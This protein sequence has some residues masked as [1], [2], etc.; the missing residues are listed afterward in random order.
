M[1]WGE[2]GWPD[3]PSSRQFPRFIEGTAPPPQLGQLLGVTTDRSELKIQATVCMYDT[4]GFI[5]QCR[6][7][8]AAAF[9]G[10]ITSKDARGR[11]HRHP[12]PPP[13]AQ[14]RTL[15]FVAEGDE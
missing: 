1:V 4:S 2:R 11:R 6:S 9:R 15:F 3:L 8:A 14:H 12:P 7:G 5:Y 13:Q 10:G